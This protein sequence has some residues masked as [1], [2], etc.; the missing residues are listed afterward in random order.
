[1]KALV[2]AALS[3]VSV[4]AMADD[5]VSSASAAQPMTQTQKYN[6]HKGLDIAKVVSTKTAQDPQNV[7]GLVK[8]QMVYLDSAGVSHSLDYT[9]QGYGRQNG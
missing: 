4:F 1:M 8:T 6:Q 7:D 2:F 5:N 3:M 9:T